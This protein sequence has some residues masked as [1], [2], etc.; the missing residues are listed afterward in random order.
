MNHP[1]PRRGSDAHTSAVDG[2]AAAREEQSRLQ[3]AAEIRKYY[4][5]EGPLAFVHVSL[6][7]NRSEFLAPLRVQVRE[8]EG[9]V[10]VW[11][12]HV[13]DAEYGAAPPIAG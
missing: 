3:K 12:D 7:N 5:V 6:L 2:L 11:G 13:G 8:E 1:R 10:V 9:N 4:A